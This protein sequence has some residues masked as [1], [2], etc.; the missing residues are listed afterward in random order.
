MG[1]AWR[2]F[3]YK[4]YLAI[5]NVVI[6]LVHCNCCMFLLQLWPHTVMTKNNVTTVLHPAYSLDLGPWDLF[7]FP[8]MK[9][10][11]KVRRFVSIEEIQGEPQQVPNTLMPA[12]LNELLPK[13][14]KSLGS[15]YTRPR[16]LLRRW[17][18]KLRLKVGIQVIMI[19]FSDILGSPS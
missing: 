19:K 13:M 11:L 7:A 1:A 17:R 10:R 12:D 2:W 5:R 15:L 4:E 3:L 8:K 16:W 9:L 6:G 14:A 18:W